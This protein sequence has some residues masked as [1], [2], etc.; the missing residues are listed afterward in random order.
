MQPVSRPV[1]ESL[2][3]RFL[4]NGDPAGVMPE[5]PG[6][7][8][9]SDNVIFTDLN[10][11]VPPTACSWSGA[12]CSSGAVSFTLIGVTDNL[13]IVDPG[14]VEEQWVPY[15]PTPEQA[16]LFIVTD[17]T[18]TK[19][20]VTL[21]FPSGGYSIRDWGALH[22]DG[23]N[24]WVDA[25]VERWTGPS[26]TV[27]TPVTHDYDLGTLAKGDY[28]FTFSAWQQPI[29]ARSFRPGSEQMVLY[30]P[31][32]GQTDISLVVDDTGP[33]ARVTILFTS[34]GFLVRDWGTLR[35]V[36]N[37]LVVNIEVEQ[38]TGPAIAVMMP[39]SHE[40]DLSG[41][42]EGDY[43]FILYAWDQHVTSESLVLTDALQPVYRF[44]SPTLSQHFYTIDAAERDKL[45][46]DYSHVWTYEGVAFNAFVDGSWANTSPVYRFWSG[47]NNA[48]FYTTDEGERAK[49][50]DELSG[51]WT[52]EGVAFYAYR[53]GY[54]PAGTDAVY[55]FW[56]AKT[57]SHFYTTSLDERDKLMNGFQDAWTY[58]EI[59]W[60]AYGL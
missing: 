58:E 16:R 32:A 26:T 7:P 56:A 50:M 17:E 18:G 29:E 59:A 54:Q 2:E 27:I 14:P 52:S 45:I 51:V 36:G 42:P 15:V 8:F 55:R 35:Q 22:Q 33:K 6:Q 40:Y 13:V 3:P 31:T 20:R 25:Q 37:T 41:V 28:T 34:G 57:N 19:A 11:K 5:L 9:S 10:Q 4:L 39:K 1:F 21:I 30:V 47:A 53:E 44:W 12:I 23:N 46:N 48:H 49:L 24:F 60:Y 38:W 43:T